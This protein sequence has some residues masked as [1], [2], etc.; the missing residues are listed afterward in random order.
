[1]GAPVRALERAWERVAGSVAARWVL[2]C[3]HASAA[4]PGPWPAE[5][6]WLAET[7][8]AWDPGAAWLTRALAAGLGAPAVLGRVSR[9]WVDLNRDAGA[10][11]LLRDRAEGR[12]VSLNRGVGAQERQERVRRWHRPYHRELAALVAAHRGAAVL[13]V[14]SF[15]PVYEGVRREVEIGVLYDRDRELAE[16]VHGA[17]LA[18]GWRARLNEPY[19][20]ANGQMFSAHH[21]ASGAGR[22]A[23]ELEIRQDLLAVDGRA[24][25]VL[26]ALLGALRA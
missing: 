12:A 3:E 16:R 22:A 24:P 21:H 13:S 20:G 17:L 26:R 10:P 25:A 6:L 2:C 15:T 14:H 11:D 7:H 1:M 18:E 4:L 9:L 19:S 5:D 8:W 23:L